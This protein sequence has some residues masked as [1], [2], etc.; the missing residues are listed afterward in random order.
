MMFLTWCWRK[1]EKVSMCKVDLRERI[2]DALNKDEFYLQVRV[3]LQ[4]EQVEKKYEDY[5]LEDDGLLAFM[6]RMYVPNY[7]SARRMALDEIHQVPY[8]GHLGY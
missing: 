4:R 7:A 5:H 3:G 1:I 2:I 6:G 8:L